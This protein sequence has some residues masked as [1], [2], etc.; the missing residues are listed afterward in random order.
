LQDKRKP[1]TV[2]FTLSAAVPI[3][4]VGRVLKAMY[5]AG[6]APSSL[7]LKAIVN[8]AAIVEHE[9]PS[10]PAPKRLSRRYAITPAEIRQAVLALVATSVRRRGSLLAAM[11]TKLA[12]PVDGPRVDKAVMD[13]K[14]LGLIAGDGEGSYRVTKRGAAQAPTQSP[15]PEPSE[16]PLPAGMRP[17]TA[18][19][20]G[21]GLFAKEPL[22]QWSNA[23]VAA[24]LTAAGHRYKAKGVIERLARHGAI[25]RAAKAKY[26]LA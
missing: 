21:Y 23:D 16:P 5:D 9:A 12:E 7:E 22:R 18:E 25:K 2:G 19:A 17:D 6:C 15:P 3:D 26:V 4:G 14:R 1:E 24:A 13:L 11:Q 10:P 20:F 8:G